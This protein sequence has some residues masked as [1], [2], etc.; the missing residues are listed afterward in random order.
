MV[1]QQGIDEV[2]GYFA[3][4]TREKLTL[5]LDRASIANG[6]KASVVCASCHGDEGRG[7]AARGVPSLMGQPPGYLV[8]QM[9]L[10]KAD[11]R[12][13]GDPALTNMKSLM[14][15]VDDA[16]LAD[17]AAYYASLGR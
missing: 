16:T 3:A 9:R 6:R 17:L 14:K 5:K 11:R 12:S 13:P 7:D 10:F 15:G 1:K 2:A 8:N 4:Q